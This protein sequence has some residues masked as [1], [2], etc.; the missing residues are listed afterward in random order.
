MINKPVKVL[1]TIGGFSARCG[2]TST[3]TY[4][5][6]SAMHGINPE[7][8]VDL[9]TPDVTESDDKLMGIGEDW[10]K[11]VSNDYKTPLSISHNMYD[12]LRDSDYDIYHTNGM[13]MHINHS[14]CAIARQK[15]KPYIITPH[16][17]LYPESL[18][19]RAWKKWP[20]R[21]LW[22]DRDIHD[23]AC[24]HA[25]CNK[26]MENLRLLGYKGPI[27]VIGNPV[28]VPDYTEELFYNRIKKT[29]PSNCIAFLGRLHPR[30]KVENI[31]RG[32]ALASKPD[33]DVHIMGEGDETYKNFLGQEASRLGI[34]NRVH[35]HGFVNGR[36]KFETLAEMD[37]LFVP[38]DFENFGMIIPE[39]LIVGTPVMASLGTPWE[40][41]NTVKCGW[42][43]D[44]TPESISKVINELYS[45]SNEDRNAMG[46]RGRDYIVRTFAADRVAAQMLSLYQWI[47]GDTSKPDFVHLL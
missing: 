19:R 12:C 30:K 18:A 13:W 29:T 26:E 42:W 6:L 36:N 25:T 27:A 28:A 39:A 46:I 22:F 16:G 37:A 15:G 17:M 47:N 9:L 3:C 1:Q 21:K 43:R 7:P 20:M 38:S 44:N 2:G 41:L 14:T 34:A 31:L 5:L 11:A 10:I 40:T 32:V 23:A 33:L 35:F 45:I 8:V 4:D 24:I